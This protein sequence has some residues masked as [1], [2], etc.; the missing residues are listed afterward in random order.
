MILVTGA[1]GLVGHEIV[2]RIPSDNLCIINRSA[3]KFETDAKVFN[4]NISPAA[5]YTVALESINCIIHCAAMVHSFKN[6]SEDSFNAV[7]LY[8]TMNLAK[9]AVKAG[10]KR[11]IF[12]STIKVN[13]E[14]T[15][16]DLPFS[17]YNSRKPKDFYAKSKSKAEEQL[18]QLADQTG[19]EVVIIRPTLVYGA[20]V[21][22]NFA[23]LMKLVSKGLPLPF[24]LV[25]S[26]KRSLVSVSNLVDLI[27]TCIEHP[28][29]K[30][31]VFLVSDDHDVSTSE[32]VSEMSI[33]CGKNNFQLPVPVWCYKFIGKLLKKEDF[34]DRL[35]GS[36]QVDISHTKETLD[37]TPPQSLRNGFKETSDYILSTQGKK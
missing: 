3:L 33:A 11:F 24:G 14:S 13:G 15:I 20:G 37:W 17:C 34:V 19:L 31:Q 23:S 21:K 1:S 8:G 18:L 9:Q 7:N 6:I 12:I 36:L 5:D 28:K 30:N 22:A 16:V 4:L 2:K 27:V 26:N 35:I 25:N 10:V 32:M 29:A